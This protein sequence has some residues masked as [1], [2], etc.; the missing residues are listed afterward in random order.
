MSATG[1]PKGYSGLQIGLHWAVV[2]LVAIQ[3]L[4]HDGI[5]AAW[6]AYRRGEAAGTE[7]SELV[8]LHVVAGAAIFVLALWRVYLRLTRGAPPLPQKEPAPLRLLA[9]ATHVLIYVL[10]IGMPISGSVAWFGGVEP[11]AGAHV[12]A[13]TVLLALIV[14]HVAGAFFQQFV[15]RTNILARMVTADD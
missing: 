9:Q 7:G 14:L 3:Y 11:A 8:W 5:E 1:H 2:A 12:L 15:L 4:A 10:L 6:R 13:K